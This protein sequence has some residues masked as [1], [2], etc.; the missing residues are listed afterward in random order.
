MLHTTRISLRRRY[1]VNP[2]LVPQ[3]E[4]AGL[5]FVGKD[6]T[7]TRMEIVELSGHK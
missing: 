7:G 6:D 2:E 3:F 1:E 4:A 5:R